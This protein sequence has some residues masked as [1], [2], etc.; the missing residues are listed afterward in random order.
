M[1]RLQAG[2]ALRAKSNDTDDNLTLEALVHRHRRQAAATV[3]VDR[4]RSKDI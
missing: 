3:I 4:G 1:C 2:E